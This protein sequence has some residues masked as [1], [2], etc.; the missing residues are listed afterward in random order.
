MIYAFTFGHFIMKDPVYIKY[1]IYH[2]FRLLQLR[3]LQPELLFL[4]LLLQLS[5]LEQS[6]LKEMFHFSIIMTILITRTSTISSF[7]SEWLK[8]SGKY[9]ENAL[10]RKSDY[11]I[12][13]IRNAAKFKILK[14]QVL[15]KSLFTIFRASYILQSVNNDFTNT[16]LP[17]SIARALQLFHTHFDPL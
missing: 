12:F 7:K 4:R 15:V 5:K 11:W 17:M 2:L 13:H 10:S 14:H 9:L 16:N 1:N 8:M 3:L 6:N